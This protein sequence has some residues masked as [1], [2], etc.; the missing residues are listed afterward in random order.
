MTTITTNTY[1]NGFAS[2]PLVDIYGETHQWVLWKYGE[3]NGKTTKIPVEPNGRWAESD[4]PATWHTLQE[5]INAKSRF[6]G[7]GLMFNGD[8]LG[9]DFD[10]CLDTSG[11]IIRPE[12]AQCISE[13]NTYAEISP[14]GKG[15]KLWVKLSE[16][17]TLVSKAKN[18]E[19]GNRIIEC[20]TSGRFFTVT[21]T[22]YGECKPVRTVD[23][24]EAIRVLSIVGYPWKADIKKSKPKAETVVGNNRE[25]AVKPRKQ[26][27]NLRFAQALMPLLKQARS[28][29]YEGGGW[30]DVGMALHELGDDGFRL[31]DEFSQQ[32]AKYEPSECAAKWE[33][34]RER[35]ND[36][37]RLTIGSIYQWACEDIGEDTVKAA[38]GKAKVKQAAPTDDELAQ[39]WLDEHPGTCYGLGESRRYNIASG[40]YE[41]VS[42]NQ[43]EA[44]ILQVLVANKENGVRP[45]AHILSSVKRIAQVLS[46]IPDEQWDSNFDLLACSNGTLHIPT[47][48]LR[49]HS[50]DNFLTSGVSY[51][52]DPRAD[53]P[54]WKRVLSENVR[55]DSVNLLQQFAGYAITT[56]TKYD[57]SIW[58]VG[59]PG[60][61]KSTV[62]EGYKA[63]LEKRCGKLGLAD[64][65]RSNFALTN[66]IGKTLLIS[67]EQP[68]NYMQSTHVLNALISGETVNVDRKFRD[69]IELNSRAKLLWAMN[70]PP[71]TQDANDGIFR[72]I[73]VIKFDRLKGPKDETV[74]EKVKE[75][76]SGIL[77]WALEGLARLRQQGKF[78]IPESV[79]ASTKR[80]QE[81]ND[82]PSVFINECCITGDGYTTQS[83]L[84][85]EAYKQWCG[86][87]NHKAQSSTT[88]AD[89]WER[90]GFKKARIVGK[91]FWRGIGLLNHR[92]EVAS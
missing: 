85:Y 13:A 15:I 81:R 91:S 18:D 7:I 74:R 88:I 63:M 11:N 64:I 87:N 65:E 38:L 1:L 34:F 40:I 61:G 73:Q 27:D 36:E 2:C 42:S 51:A 76:G 58:L 20:Y 89:D 9:I 29:A 44:E 80:Y 45:A 26:S 8:T 52:Y 50:P 32:S 70:T 53:A 4:N 49:P 30:I 56:D 5:V 19:N 12:V 48:T 28:E 66:I 46:H 55:T 69:P 92:E 31:W 57:L 22:P 37:N 33:T 67:T 39:Q 71:R 62:I 82:I 14:S 3:R 43:V 41:L 6:V 24:T 23:A 77:N 68:A 79:G 10:D 60:T 90:L 16:P 54:T 84:L 75:E 25:K 17:L 83:S 78:E 59:E 21:N 86:I 72:R 35:G 47:L